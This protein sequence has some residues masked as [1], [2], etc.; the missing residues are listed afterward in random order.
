M[1]STRD[2]TSVTF[3]HIKQNLPHQPTKEY[4]I[5]PKK[6]SDGNIALQESFLQV[7]TTLKEQLY[8]YC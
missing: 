3:K 2:D 1:R 8:L 4:S 6:V 7:D 5:S